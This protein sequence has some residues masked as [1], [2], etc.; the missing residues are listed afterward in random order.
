DQAAAVA[1]RPRRELDDVGRACGEVEEFR[2]T[3]ADQERRPGPLHR[4]R[5]TAVLASGVVSAVE[6]ER[7]AA[8]GA[9]NELDGLLQPRDAHA[10]VVEADSRLGIVAHVPTGADA[11][12]ETPVGE[13]VDRRRVLR[14]HEWMT[15]VVAGHESADAERRRR[16]GSRCK[17][18]KRRELSSEVIRDKKYVVPS[19]LRSRR[20]FTPLGSRV[21]QA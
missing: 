8:P 18:R 14:E 16:L 20:G 13:E 5:P 7:L 6:A 19:R 4:Q 17:S 3:R 11:Q 1:Y 10:G 9:P 12:L 2:R 21:R 15:E